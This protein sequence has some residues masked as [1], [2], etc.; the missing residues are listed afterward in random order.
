MIFQYSNGTRIRIKKGW[1]DFG[2]V[3][4][5]LGIPIFVDQLW[6]P[7]LWDNEED[8]EFFKLAGV[9]RLI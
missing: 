9:E 7:V 1:E 3:G 5:C 2:Q 6:I 4:T 8:P